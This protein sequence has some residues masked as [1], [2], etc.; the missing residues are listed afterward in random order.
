VNTD[1]TTFV[2]ELQKVKDP[3][4]KA[5]EK[6][7]CQVTIKIKTYTLYPEYTIGNGSGKSAHQMKTLPENQLELV[8]KATAKGD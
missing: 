7:D 6:N 4:C 3:V 8:W 1:T 5:P 2:K